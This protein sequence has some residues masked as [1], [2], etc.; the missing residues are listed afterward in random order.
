MLLY[1]EYENTIQYPVISVSS[2]PTLSLVTTAEAKNYLRIDSSITA[3][4][5]LIGDLLA[6]S[7]KFVESQINQVLVETGFVQKQTGGCNTL[8]LVKSPLVGNP[9]VEYYE[10]FDSVASLKTISTDFRVVENELHN[11]NSYWSSGRQGDGYSITYTA[12][13]FTAGSY[14]SSTDK[15]LQIIKTAML[16]FCAWL[17]ES[18]EEFSGD[19]S[20]DNFTQKFSKDVPNGIINSLMPLCDGRNIL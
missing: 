7:A 16:R 8:E 1:E 4:D 19:L 12:G 18:R 20:E 11:V 10:K 14:T 17:Y 9:V 6:V 3:D 13:M 15:N 5:S 2:Q